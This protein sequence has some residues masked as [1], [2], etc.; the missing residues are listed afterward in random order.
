MIIYFDTKI[1]WQTTAGDLDELTKRRYY[2]AAPPYL[3]VLVLHEDVID[4]L[5]GMA[6]H[7][8]GLTF[9]CSIGNHASDAPMGYTLP[10]YS[11]YRHTKI[12]VR[13][14][15]EAQPEK[16]LSQILAG[17]PREGRGDL[18]LRAPEDSEELCV[19]LPSILTE[20]I[21]QSAGKHGVTVDDLVWEILL[22]YIENGV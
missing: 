13:K 20:K 17:A 7:L 4:A 5:D 14:M 12:T 11:G 8:H 3:V 21:R 2:A 18:G 19:L 10:R 6:A 15:V 9:D 16:T 1:K 22:D